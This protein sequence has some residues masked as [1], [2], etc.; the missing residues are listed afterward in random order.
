MLA[1]GA[2][3]LSLML[4]AAQEE[5]PPPGPLELGVTEETGTSLAQIDVTLTGPAEALAQVRPES[6]QVWVGGKKLDRVLADGICPA[7]EPH[8]PGSR[9][10]PGP[11]EAASPRPASWPTCSSTRCGR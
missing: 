1:R 9:E 3:V 10:K 5:A 8:A 2:L 11:A 4:L 7:A 6:F